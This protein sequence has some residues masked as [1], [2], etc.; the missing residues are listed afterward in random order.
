MVL[1]AR[2]SFLMT[3]LWTKAVTIPA[4]SLTGTANSIVRKT[5]SSL[6]CAFRTGCMFRWAYNLPYHGVSLKFPNAPNG[7][8]PEDRRRIGCTG[9]PR[10]TSE[11]GGGCNGSCSVP[12]AEP[13]TVAT[14]CVTPETDLLARDIATS[15]YKHSV[16]TNPRS[17]QTFRLVARS[18][19]D[20]TRYDFWTSPIQP[21]AP[22]RPPLLSV[23][24]SV[25]R[26][27]NPQIRLQQRR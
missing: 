12:L 1:K 11:G 3:R 4:G 18:T 25:C 20:R 22:W 8:R 26:V 17:L 10:A 14:W 19:G 9:M 16:A 13:W 27:W 5:E 7:T 2:F 15:L 23:P 21:T 24:Y 6:L